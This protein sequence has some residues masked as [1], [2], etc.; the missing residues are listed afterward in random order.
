MPKGR[1]GRFQWRGV[2][3]TALAFAAMLWALMSGL[4]QV[5]ERSDSEQVRVLSD[6]VL[7]ATLTCYAVE[8][9]YPASVEY[10][11]TNYGIVYDE[12]EYIVTLDAFAS[13]LLPEIYVLTQG[14]EIR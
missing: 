8:G 12:E 11:K 13:N 14:G 7:R 9:R 4:S 1:V 2:L 10:L 5:D 3:V 6:A